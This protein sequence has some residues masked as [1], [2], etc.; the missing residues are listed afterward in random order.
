MVRTNL[1]IAIVAMVLAGN[2]TISQYQEAT[3]QSSNITNNTVHVGSLVPEPQYDWNEYE[4]GQVLGAFFWTYWMGQLPGGILAQKYGTKKVFGFSNLFMCLATF[5]IPWCSKM[6]V[7]A[8]IALRMLQGL[9][10][11]LAWPSLHDMT[12]KWIP[13]N[14]RSKFVTAYMGSSVG[15]ALTY[16][17]CGLIIYYCGWRAVF[18]ITGTIGV[19]WAV[20]WW[21]FVHDSPADHPYISGRELR[22]IQSSLFE[23]VSK[24]KSLKPVVTN[25]DVPPKSTRSTKTDCWLQE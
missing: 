22:Y 6:N 14:E 24:K 9:V 19:V 11:G 23:S 15:A 10:G 4:Q 13:P 2:T 18:Y 8:L 5:L 20:A 7:L 16:P 17:L 25:W 1:N 3:R 21:K 12:A